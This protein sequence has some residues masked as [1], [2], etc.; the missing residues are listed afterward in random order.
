MTKITSTDKKK[1]SQ[2]LLECQKKGLLQYGKYL[3]DQLKASANKKLKKQYHSYIVDQI[4]LNDK[5]IA[6]IDVKIK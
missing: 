1:F 2:K 4:A 6:A 5:R 3:N